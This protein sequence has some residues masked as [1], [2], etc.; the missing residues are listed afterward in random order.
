MYTHRP[1]PILPPTG[2]APTNPW[3]LWR[4]EM[5]AEPE[6]LT[7]AELAECCCPELCDRDHD[8]D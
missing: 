8:N 4:P 1:H 5:P 7:V 6:R 2:M 3:L